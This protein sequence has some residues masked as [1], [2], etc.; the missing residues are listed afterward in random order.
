M[1]EIG[2]INPAAKSWLQEIK[3]KHWSRYAYDHVI[4]CDHVTNNM[5]E[6]FNSMIGTHIVSS[7]LELLE[8]IRRMVMRKFQERKE[9]CQQW[10]SVLPSRVNAKILKNSKQ[11]RVLTIIAAGNMEYEFLGPNE[12]Y[13]VKL[14]EYSCQCGSWQVSGIPCRHAMATISHHCGKAAVK[15]KVSEY[16]HQCLTKSAYMQTYSE[17]IHP[18]LDQKRWLEV[19]V[20]VLIEGQTE[21]IDPSPCIVQPER[22]K[23]QRKREPDEGP[24]GGKSGT[25]TCKLCSQV[26]HSKRTCKN[27][28]NE[29]STTTSSSHH[30]IQQQSALE[31]SSS[32]P[33]P[34]QTQT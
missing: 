29:T 20:S 27:K 11:S 12:G 15:D 18:I 7:Y 28:T 33:P 16:V 21:H 10:N 25:V 8:F 6:A 32:Q 19:P 30:P 26:G 3:P 1:D 17:M 5:T 9:E 34:I 22:P 4:R 23:T 24:K 13:A 2:A 14:G 31:G